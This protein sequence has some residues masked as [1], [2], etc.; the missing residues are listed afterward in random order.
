M[1]LI[2][3][4]SDT[5]ISVKQPSG[6][7]NILKLQEI[8]ENLGI[9]T[10]VDAISGILKIRL[11]DFVV[12]DN[13]E[14]SRF[15]DCF[16]SRDEGVRFSLPLEMSI[17]SGGS[18]T[19][20][21]K[22]E[23]F[24]NGFKAGLLLDYS[25]TDDGV[26]SADLYQFYDGTTTGKVRMSASFIKEFV[27]QKLIGELDTFYIENYVSFL[28]MFIEQYSQT[29]ILKSNTAEI[30][31]ILLQVKNV[32]AYVFDMNN[33]SFYGISM[34]KDNFTISTLDD[35]SSNELLSSMY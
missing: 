3:I 28:D 8:H 7:A 16:T 32:N 1:A 19:V 13:D 30:S 2:F 6:D 10:A 33:D 34:G 29:N 24:I 4:P 9:E 21:E 5:L 31:Q 11:H 20:L 26:Y 14:F 12:M 15:V 18:L 25:K 27:S 35:K 23:Q 17:M 22:G